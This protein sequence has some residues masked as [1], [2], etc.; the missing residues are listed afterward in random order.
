LTRADSLAEKSKFKV[1]E[2]IGIE[3]GEA[4]FNEKKITQKIL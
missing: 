4:V 1:L 2:K 3:S